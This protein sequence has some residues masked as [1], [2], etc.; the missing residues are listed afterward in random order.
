MAKSKQA[1]PQRKPFDPDSR[2]PD[3][4]PVI[5]HAEGVRDALFDEL[6]L[7]RA[8]KVTTKHGRTMAFLAKQ[9]IECAR[10]EIS[11]QQALKNVEPLR[12]GTGR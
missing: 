6:D 7:L 11:Q 9:I 3:L 5:R 1:D 2:A 4:P 12:L 10:L 8:N